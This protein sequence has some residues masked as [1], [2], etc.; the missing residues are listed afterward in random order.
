LGTITL[1]PDNTRSINFGVDKVSVPSEE[2]KET[3]TKKSPEPNQAKKRAYYADSSS[4]NSSS[5]SLEHI[6][7]DIH[8]KHQKIIKESFQEP[9]VARALPTVNLSELLQVHECA[10][11]NDEKN[12]GKPII[13]EIDR[14]IFLYDIWSPGFKTIV[15]R[16]EFKVYESKNANPCI[17]RYSITNQDA[18]KYCVPPGSKYYIES[19]RVNSTGK[20][21]L[22][23]LS[24][25][26]N[27]K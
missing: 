16:T 3:E 7:Q 17:Q 19:V 18:I 4:S 27:N 8:Q 26:R 12:F 15:K 23:I 13:T 14:L 11:L 5:N 6:H 25:Y 2:T 21:N 1:E 20:E 10:L 9:T 24:A 22:P